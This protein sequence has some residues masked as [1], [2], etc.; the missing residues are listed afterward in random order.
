MLKHYYLTFYHEYTAKI[1]SVTAFLC[2]VKVV[3]VQIEI[4]NNY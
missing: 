2:S 3:K 1:D 4:Y